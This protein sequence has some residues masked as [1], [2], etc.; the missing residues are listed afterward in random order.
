MVLLALSGLAGCT[1]VDA[2]D[3]L[4]QLMVFGFV[5]FD[6]SDAFLEAT[7]EQLV[8]LVEAQLEDLANGYRVNDLSGDDLAAAGVDAADLTGI[9]GAM[10]VVEYDHDLSAIVEA[11]SAEDKDVRWP[12]NFT[13]YN[14]EETSDRPCFL[15]TDCDRLDQTIHEVADLGPPLNSAERTYA[16][17]YRWVAS[18]TLP[19]AVFVRQLSPDPVDVGWDAMSVNQQYS[20]VMIY[21]VDGHA[22]RVE[23]FWVD[24]EFV[25]IDVPDDF[26]VNAAVSQMGKQAENIDA[27][28][29]DN[30]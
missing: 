29:A 27:W 8:P 3:N 19:P 22:R 5:N 20:L 12:D 2:P 15:T 4:E 24:A 30:P 13:T 28:I 16:A 17:S 21:E 1:V 10:G 23:S 26:A 11:A 7:E 25:G 6:E 18:D 9:V 14:V